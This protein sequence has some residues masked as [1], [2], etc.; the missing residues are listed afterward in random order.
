MQKRKALSK[1]WNIRI[2]GA[3]YLWISASFQNRVLDDKAI[4]QEIKEWAAS[5]ICS[6]Y[7]LEDPGR[8]ELSA[9]RRRGETWPVTVWELSVSP[10]VQ[11]G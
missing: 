9:C 3:L 5:N 2:T 11:T 6:L 1:N 10:V 7:R 4:P 8:M